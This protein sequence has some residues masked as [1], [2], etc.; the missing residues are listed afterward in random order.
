MPDKINSE[1]RS[2][3]S[4]KIFDKTQEYAW[5]TAVEHKIPYWKLAD[6]ALRFYCDHLNKTSP[7]I[8]R[9]AAVKIS[10]L[11]EDLDNIKLQVVDLEA[12]LEFYREKIPGKIPVNPQH[13][14]EE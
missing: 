6:R 2:M 13:Q 5:K 7:A 1:D 4:R 8:D 9:H 10:Q 11:V 3:W 12:E 14:K